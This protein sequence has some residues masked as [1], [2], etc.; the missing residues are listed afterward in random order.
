[1]DLIRKMR[2]SGRSSRTSMTARGLTSQP[3]DG[4]GRELAWASGRSIDGRVHGLAFVARFR[5]A[6]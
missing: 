1:M 4:A 6:A 3:P 2:P 5:N